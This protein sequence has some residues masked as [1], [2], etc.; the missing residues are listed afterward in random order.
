[1]AQT[2]IFS[3]IHKLFQ[4]EKLRMNS[5]KIFS[6]YFQDFNNTTRIKIM[7]GRII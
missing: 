7:K 2:M 3:I 1:M 5:Y 6:K 4:A